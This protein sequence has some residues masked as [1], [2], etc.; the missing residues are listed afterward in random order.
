[1]SRTSFY[2]RSMSSS[3]RRRGYSPIP[4]HWT[5][6]GIRYVGRNCS[7]F[8][9]TI[10][11]SARL[12]HLYAAFAA[13]SF[14]LASLGPRIGNAGR[15]PWYKAGL[16]LTALC[17]FLSLPSSYNGPPPWPDSRGLRQG[18]IRGPPRNFPGHRPPEQAA[19]DVHPHLCCD[20]TLLSRPW[21]QRQAK[22]A[23]PAPDGPGSTNVY[24]YIYIY[25]TGLRARSPP[26]TRLGFP[27][28]ARPH[29]S[30]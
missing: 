7:L 29:P 14:L 3:P 15:S 21:R 11:V 30:Q 6:G 5:L 26:T 17:G 8:P 2:F 24:I 25:T 9:A 22:A 10:S 4:R 13:R 19:H 20:L 16:P 12:R 28:S 23:R 27:H 1:M 18:S